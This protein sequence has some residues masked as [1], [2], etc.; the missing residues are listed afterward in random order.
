VKSIPGIKT[1]ETGDNKRIV[2]HWRNVKPAGQ[3]GAVSLEPGRTPDVQVSSFLS[4]EEVGRWYEELER[5]KRVP[6]QEI[7][8]KADELTK[9]VNTEGEKVEA[10]YNFAAKKVKYISLVS[11][12]I[13]GY[14]PHPA[15]ETLR[16]LYG[17]CKD[18]VAL[19][20]AL[21]ESEGL[22]AS[23]LLISADRKLDLEVPSPWPFDH[24]ITML[25][26]GKNRIWL[27][28]SPAVLPL[29]MLAPSLRGKEGLLMPWDGVPHFEK[30]PTETP[31][32]NRWTEE[33]TGRIGE[34]GTLEA[35][36]QITARG[37]AELGLRQAF[38]GPVE[39][40]WPATV[41]G[42]VKGI[43]RKTDKVSDVKIGD[44]TDTSKAFTLS[45]RFSRPHFASFA[46]GEAKFRLPLAGIDLP[47]AEEEG[48]MDTA[49]GWH[50]VEAEPVRLGLPGERSYGVKLELPLGCSPE[51]PGSVFLKQA[52]LTY[53]GTYNSD[54]S[55]LTAERDLTLTKDHL[56]AN[57]RVE[58]AVFREKVLADVNRILSARVTDS[59]AEETKNPM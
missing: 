21:L 47:S 44:P 51:L 57:F 54:G 40:A 2:H 3:F 58:Y 55:S 6:S 1:W 29:G 11:L 35:A 36:V 59:R 25:E 19:L 7:K 53:S 42:V 8:A 4:W 9:G 37:D 46:K 13:G 20:S 56:A 18:K 32:A 33:V 43:D 48:V 17:D 24:V 49:G 45:F 41:E 27:D 30:T 31:L 23:S 34:D 15:S 5:S 12:G 22:H 14:E 38:I 10:L 16:N 52:G 26:L 39:A 50:R 28:P